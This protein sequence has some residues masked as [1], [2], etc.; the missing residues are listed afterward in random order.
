MLCPDNT[1]KGASIMANHLNFDNRLDIE[2]FLKD[3]C[4]ISEIGR[5][6]NRHKSTISR[7]IT[8]RSSI[9]MKG[10]YGRNYNACIYRYDC[11]LTN[12]CKEC[13]YDN[14]HDKFCKFCSYCNNNCEY[15]KEDICD[16]LSSS[17]YVCNGCDNRNKCTLTKKIYSAKLAQEDY[18][19]MLVES[20][21]GI[22]ITPEEVK[23]IDG[24]IKPLI[25]NGHSIHH[26][27]SNNKGSIMVCERTLYNYID[28]QILSTKN[29]DLPRKVRYRPRKK[30]KMGYKVDKECLGGR[31]YDDYLEFIEKN[32]DI[33]I[34]QMDTVEGKK[35]G[36]VLLTIHFIDSSFMLMLLRD[37][38]DSKSVTAWFEWIYNAVGKNEFKRLFP[39]ILTDN[40]SE[41]S[42][43]NRIERIQDEDKL[44]SVF[45]CYPY[46][47]FLKPEIE[48]NHELIRRV[49]PKGKSMDGLT[50]TDITL[51]MSHINSYTRKKLN[52]HSPFDSFS[53]RYGFKL[54][55]ALGIKKID[56]NDVILKPSLIFK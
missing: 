3:N 46:S 15:F 38:N 4:S 28:N 55:N 19:N 5:L 54:I 9:S 7:E 17:P 40:G 27:H 23:K 8:L 45:F 49:I 20:R 16:K 14:K 37:A 53:Q 43:P 34:V 6:L 31:R 11:D 13:R 36:K 25:D 2:R 47:S 48:N 26:I 18:E 22:E 1:S 39:V 56:P 21:T 29:I 44:T 10:C 33:S 50:Q 12:I 30:I 51:L 42:D 32:K 24:I 52:D 41:F 35:G